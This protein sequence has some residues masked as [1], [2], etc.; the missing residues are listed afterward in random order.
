[1]ENIKNIEVIY[2]K[3]A[4]EPIGPYSQATKFNGLIFT[5]GQLGI[6]PAT[7]V[8]AGSEI[9]RQA[10]QSLYNLERILTAANS[11]LSHVIETVIYLTNIKDFQAVNK[12]YTEKM[13]GHKPAR[14]TVEV[15]SLPLFSKIEIKMTA[16]EKFSQP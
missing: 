1:M 3:E 11:D 13:K 4:P 7:G 12:I 15:S 14:T 10:E 9:E 8:L 5:S 6:D 2:T 16:A